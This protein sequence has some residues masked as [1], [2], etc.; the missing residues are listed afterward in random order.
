[1][2]GFLFPLFASAA[3]TYNTADLFSGAEIQQ[4]ITTNNAIIEVVAIPTGTVIPPTIIAGTTIQATVIPDQVVPV[5]VDPETQVFEAEVDDKGNIVSVVRVLADSGSHNT[6]L[7]TAGGDAG[8][9]AQATVA[10][11]EVISSA[12]QVVNTEATT[13]ATATPAASADAA[14]GAASAAAPAN[15]NGGTKFLTAFVT[16]N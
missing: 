14:S 16:A 5:V 3:F 11:P 1:M 6:T 8:S 13:Y 9:A 4:I 12:L 2:I 7:V 15:A 10:T